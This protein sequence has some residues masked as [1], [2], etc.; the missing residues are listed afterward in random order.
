ME[1]WFSNFS[2]HYKYFEGSLKYR[3]LP[4]EFWIKILGGTWKLALLTSSQVEAA[5]L[6]ITP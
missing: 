5:G 4:S 1:Q 2:G 3:A 6:R